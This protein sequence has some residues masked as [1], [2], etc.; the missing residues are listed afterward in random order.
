MPTEYAPRAVPPR[1]LVLSLAALIVPVAGALEAPAGLG[2]Y[3]ALLWLLALVPAFL[4]AYYRGWRGVATAL[5]AGMATLAVTQVL[6]LWLER[7]IPSVLLGVVVA[8]LGLALG[9]GWLAEK[10]HRDRAVVEEMAFTDLLTRLPN[11]RHAR[12]F[13]DNAFGAA[14]RGRRLS[15]VL[16][17][18]DRFKSYNDQWGHA[19]GDAA[20]REFAA[21]LD[22]TTRRMDLSSRFGGEEFLSVLTGTDTEGALIFAD[23]IRAALATTELHE[24]RHLTV[25]A[26]VATYH[27][28]MRS[29]DELIAAADDA[30][31]R[32]K[33]E[34]RNRVRLFGASTSEYA[35]TLSETADR[36]PEPASNESSDYP[37]PAEEI[38][39]T[40]PPPAL[41][42]RRITGFGGGR[43]VLVVESDR[44]VRSLVT[45]YLGSEGFQVVDVGDVMS[46]LGALDREF[47]AVVTG[48]HLPG[49]PGV[50]LVAAV[51]A[52][53]P[54]TQI[55]V[56]TELH[57]TRTAAEALNA[58]ADRHLVK[59]FGVADLRAHLVD[60]LERRERM[61][62][63]WTDRHGP[64]VTARAREARATETVLAAVRALAVATEL[65]DPCK[66]GHGLRVAAY[67]ERVAA[68]LGDHDGASIAGPSL[69]LACE[70]HD[71]GKVGVAHRILHKE[72]DL[73]PD[74]LRQMK[75]HPSLGGRILESIL[76]DEDVLS[77][78]RWH[79]ERWD[80]AGYPDGL[81]G[82][83]IPLAA[84]VASV[85]DTLDA[86]TCDRPYR[87]A[88]AWDHAVREI[89][90]QSGRQFDPKVVAAMDSCL[91]DLRAMFEGRSP[92]DRTESE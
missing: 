72:G 34:G 67:A 14:Q 11:R 52:R 61:L 64:T 74:E 87:R 40:P 81:S 57:D 50:E 25:S 54:A 5:A 62:R 36:S 59:P 10:L 6:A 17:D 85:C 88:H 41:L 24:G 29:P 51:K 3:A 89:R 13:L 2:S 42:P 58:G 90:A 26:G 37:R 80:G 45:S 73:T 55:L 16:F 9:I 66:H 19:A 20:L 86:M 43:R 53:W 70:I 78:V 91:A 82:E 38:G 23:R 28:D 4:L 32:A 77:V 79:H 46:G 47:D 44:Q 49:A 27:P 71:L 30:L 69:R 18:L 35:A 65:H 12:A 56:I 31:Y 60:A 48:L 8:Y 1:A 76:D 21:I 83:E 39:R 15:V 63:A 7:T 75:E 22:P 92:E 33:R 68:A 84:R